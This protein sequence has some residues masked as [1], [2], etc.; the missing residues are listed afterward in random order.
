[1]NV[2]VL[3]PRMTTSA[4]RISVRSRFDVRPVTPDLW[5]ALEDLFGKAGA[6]N[7]CWCMYWRIGPRY[8]QLP[9][10]KNKRALRAIVK[11]GPPPGL[12]A[13][14]GGLAVGWCEVCPRADL[15]H[16]DET[17]LLKRVDDKPVWSIACFFVRRGYRRAGVTSALIGEAVKVARRAGA[18]ALEAYPID[19][20]DPQAP[21]N[22]YTGIASTFEKHGFKTVARRVPYRPVMRRTFR[23]RRG[24]AS[25]KSAAR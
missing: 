17:R 25:R 24:K 10:D 23:F 9:R 16:L 13:F 1:M 7:G 18:P 14:D 20:R 3:S 11:R 5:P 21:G 19:K 8:N 22:I 2:G 12:L 15:P 4:L 6:C